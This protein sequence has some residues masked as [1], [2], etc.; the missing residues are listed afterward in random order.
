MGCQLI[1]DHAKEKKTSV[2]K[3]K[4]RSKGL[5]VL[6][7]V[8]GLLEKVSRVFK[9]HGFATSLK[10]HCTI[11]NAI[12]HPKHKRDSLQTAEVVYEIT[13]KNCPKTYIGETGR[14]LTT[15]LAEHKSETDKV[16]TKSYT[17]SQRKAQQ[18]LLR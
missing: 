3:N 10:R 1:D 7:Y 16:E 13:C 15:R 11:R 12:V 14:L 6:L 9:Q 5:V 2:N 18:P 4:D 17:R 8:E